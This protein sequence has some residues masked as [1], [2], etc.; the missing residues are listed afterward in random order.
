MADKIRK[1]LSWALTSVNPYGSNSATQKNPKYIYIHIY[2]KPFSLHLHIRYTA[3]ISRRKHVINLD[4]VGNIRSIQRFQRCIHIHVPSSYRKNES[5]LP[6]FSFSLS[7]SLYIW[8]RHNG[9]YIQARRNIPRRCLYFR[10]TSYNA[11]VADERN[12]KDWEVDTTGQDAFCQLQRLV[13]FE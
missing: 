12:E 1:V 3:R 4:C 6:R 9:I 8:N 5:L 10:E 13:G 11:R 7:L 2:V